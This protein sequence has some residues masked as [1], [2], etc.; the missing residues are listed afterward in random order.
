[1]HDFIRKSVLVA[2]PFRQYNAYLIGKADVLHMNTSAQDP[3]FDF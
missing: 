1:V 2:L 3:M